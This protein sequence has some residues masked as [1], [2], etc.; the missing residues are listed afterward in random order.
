MISC[1]YILQLTLS[2]SPSNP[3]M[4]S[5]GKT[6][7]FPKA[8]CKILLRYHF[9]FVWLCNLVSR[10]QFTAFAFAIPPGKWRVQSALTYERKRKIGF[11]QLRLSPRTQEFWIQFP[12]SCVTLGK[13]HWI[14]VPQFPICNMGWILL[15]F[16]HLMSGS[17]IKIV[18]ASGQGQSQTMCLYS[19]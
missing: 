5:G 8:G 17:P 16:S 9:I 1:I 2:A 6:F 11:L 10:R 12:L 18:S 19:A 7:F 15:P 13:L 3:H 14:S 4:S